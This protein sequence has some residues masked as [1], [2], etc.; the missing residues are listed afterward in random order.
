VLT[1]RISLH[2]GQNLRRPRA[3]R[4]IFGGKFRQ[5]HFQKLKIKKYI[6]GGFLRVC[7][8]FKPPKTKREKK[9]EPK[10]LQRSQTAGNFRRGINLN[11]K[12]CGGCQPPES[13]G[14]EILISKK[15]PEKPNKTAANV[16]A[17][18]NG[19]KTTVFFFLIKLILKKLV[20]LYYKIKNLFKI[21]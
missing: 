8:G 21:S 5:K 1:I 14:R 3:H 2:T 10:D 13:F 19:R 17:D 6:S 9:I 12:I 16:V 11:I 20:F 4:T 18:K 7:G 15:P